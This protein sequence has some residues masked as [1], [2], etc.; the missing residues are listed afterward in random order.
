MELRALGEFIRDESSGVHTSALAGCLGIAAGM[1]LVVRGLPRPENCLDGLAVL[2]LAA[3]ALPKE[4]IVTARNIARTPQL[5]PGYGGLKPAER[6]VT[7]QE[8]TGPETFVNHQTIEAAGRRL[9]GRGMVYVPLRP[10]GRLA[11]LPQMPRDLAQAFQEL[12]AEGLPVLAAL[13]TL[14]LEQA[15]E[16]TRACHARNPG[17][18]HGVVKTTLRQL[19]ER[20]GLAPAGK[21]LRML[22]RMLATLSFVHVADFTL[23]EKRRGAAGKGGKAEAKEIRMALGRLIT[24]L[25]YRLRGGRFGEATVVVTLC[26]ALTDFL[27]SP[28]CRGQMVWVPVDA[29][30]K[31]RRKRRRS[32]HSIQLLFFLLAANPGRGRPFRI[33]WKK[34]A[35]RAGIPDRTESGRPVRPAEK[36]RRVGQIMADIAATGV[37]EISEENGVYVV[38]YPA[39]ANGPRQ[40][41]G[42]WAAG[43]L[44]RA[45]GAPEGGVPCAR[46]LGFS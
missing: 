26:P 3:Q 20:A 19:A 38:R 7:V 16:V 18:A 10:M 28:E 31:L 12:P 9:P 11:G 37:V 24:W 30:K 43:H 36:R 6:P 23:A 2:P 8:P 34:A 46:F 45:Q 42:Q 25:E 40:A 22:A 15:D 5:L 33:G 17:M 32:R 29:I 35:D 1:W 39:V 41:S 14:F 44:W 4:K 21:N 13:C 27:L